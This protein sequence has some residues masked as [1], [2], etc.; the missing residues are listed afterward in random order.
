MI[1]E[2]VHLTKALIGIRVFTDDMKFRSL[3]DF[4]VQLTLTIFLFIDI[5]FVLVAMKK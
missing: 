2:T 5:L 3:T 1:A 4:V